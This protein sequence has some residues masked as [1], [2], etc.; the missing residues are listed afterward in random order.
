MAQANLRSA[1]VRPREQFRLD[2]LRTARQ[3]G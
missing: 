1:R 2:H 3:L